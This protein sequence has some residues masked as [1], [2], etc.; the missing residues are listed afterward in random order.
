MDH[1]YGADA[2]GAIGPVTGQEGLGVVE[3]GMGEPVPVV[4]V[5]EL[6]AT[7]LM[8]ARGAAHPGAEPGAPWYRRGTDV[9]D[10]LQIDTEGH[11]AAVLRGARETLANRRVR[12]LEFEWSEAWPANESVTRTVRDLARDGYTCFWQ[13]GS[14][15]LAPLLRN[16]DYKGTWKK[17]W[18]NLVCA[19]EPAVVQA[20]STLVRVP[21]LGTQGLVKKQ[22][23][24]RQRWIAPPE[25]MAT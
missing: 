23:R 12:V 20:M 9:V 6:V 11:D 24:L 8:S 4:T 21:W 3:A 25:A 16:C 7:K 1:T 15:Q 2:W 17:H 22:R 18:S 19:H 13:G 10:L 14:N 5:D